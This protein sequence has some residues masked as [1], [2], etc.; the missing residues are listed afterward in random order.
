MNN[1]AYLANSFPEAVEPY[2]WEEIREL[3][4]RGTA[5]VACSFRRP[6]QVPADAAEIALETAYLFPINPWIALYACWIFFFRLVFIA[7]PL[8][9]AV[10]GPESMQ[11]RLRTIAHTWL[12]AY[13]AAV[14]WK[15]QIAHIH[16]HHGYFSSWAG[17]V[18][19]RI[20]GATFSL[21][22]HGSDLLVRADYLDCK[23]KHCK[24]CITVSEFNRRHV[25]EHYL[26]ANSR[27]VLVH[28]LGV[29]L[30]FWAPGRNATPACC[31][32][33]VSVG[34]LHPVK[35]HEFLIRACYELKNAGLKFHCMIAG[36]GYERD[37]LHDLI[38]QMCL[39]NEIE[40]CGHVE[41]AELRTLYSQADVVVLTSH[42]EGIPLTLME[43]MAMERVVLAPAITAIPE[44]ISD[45]QTGFLYQQHSLPD[46]L[47]RVLSIAGEPPLENLRQEAR[48]NIQ[49]HFN[50]QRN[51]H[52]WAE[53]FL[54]HLGGTSQEQESSHAHPV[55]Q[56]VQLPV[57][58]DRSISV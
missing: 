25:R 47:D 17:M 5:V 53:D 23:L 27:K 15:K 19:A 45:G 36:D 7:E 58:R 32:S 21:T 9:R 20:L 52:S 37:H 35:N 4:I 14:L 26:E 6:R 44:L 50:R 29:D 42:S 2:V 1:I 3:R 31:F 30:D 18:A 41:R 46:F 49:L 11:Q 48:R 34:R 40:F 8:W 54:R 33:I 10:R 28:R 38:N 57:Q 24:F 55:L 51:L 12:G 22:L 13:L 43:A 56:Q 16:I 39:Q